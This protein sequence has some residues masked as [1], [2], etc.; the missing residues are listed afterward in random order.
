MLG[1]LACFLWALF[2]S[3][4]RACGQCGLDGWEGAGGGLL[5]GW[6]V[7]VLEQVARLGDAGCV[8]GRVGFMFRIV[9]EAFGWGVG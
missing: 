4:H 8:V 5:A 6:V 9:G 1:L 3:S 2:L 7:V